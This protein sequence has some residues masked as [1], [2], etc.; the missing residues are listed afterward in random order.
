MRPGGL[1]F[2][3]DDAR[4]AGV[5]SSDEDVIVRK[6]IVHHNIIR[7]EGES[8][9]ESS[10]EESEE[11]SSE[12]DSFIND[13]EE[14]S[15]SEGSQKESSEDEQVYEE[16]PGSEPQHQVRR[17]PNSLIGGIDEEPALQGWGTC[18]VREGD[19]APKRAAK[20][21]RGRPRGSL[22]V[23]KRLTKRLAEGTASVQPASQEG[24]L[25]I[26]IFRL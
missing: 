16:I 21:G 23:L 22:G 5:Y 20:R 24:E 18:P 2:V 13:E 10:E 15:E 25:S 26:L 17:N 3:D 9:E 11:E 12:V 8:E 1:A 7:D 19:A 4:I 6:E 14:G